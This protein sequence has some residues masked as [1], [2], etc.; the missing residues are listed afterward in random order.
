VRAILKHIVRSTFPVPHHHKIT[1]I[2][3][4]KVKAVITIILNRITRVTPTITPIKI[5][6]LST[7]TH[8]LGLLV[9]AMTMN[10]GNAGTIVAGIPAHP[11]TVTIAMPPGAMTGM[12]DIE[13]LFSLYGVRTSR[14]SEI[15]I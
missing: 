14:D 10:A 5:I 15:V 3:A 7:K 2:E 11:N 13:F 4:P 9:P 8:Q 12:V 1:T 6:A